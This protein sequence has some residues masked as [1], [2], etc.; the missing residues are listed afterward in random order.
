MNEYAY[1]ELVAAATK[2]NATQEDINAL[3]EWFEHYGMCYWNGS[4]WEVDVKN[5][6][7]LAQVVKE[8]AEDEFEVIGY[9]F[10]HQTV[11]ADSVEC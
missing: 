9:A 8:V 5:D 2:C 1:E 4:C 7:C 3:G 6:I 10:S 11:L